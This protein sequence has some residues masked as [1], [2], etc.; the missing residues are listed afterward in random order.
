[1]ARRVSGPPWFIGIS[2]AAVG[3]LLLLAYCGIETLG[4]PPER[5]PDQAP[6]AVVDQTTPPGQ[7]PATTAT[8][9]DDGGAAVPG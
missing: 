2:L 5:P 1:M 9:T 8:P 6:P 3:L 4:S 7:P